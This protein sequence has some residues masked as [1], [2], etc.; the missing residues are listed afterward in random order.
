MRN[1]SNL[2]PPKAP[3]PIILGAEE[4]KAYLGMINLWRCFDQYFE[5]L[6]ET[7]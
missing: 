7:A 6:Q 2:V 3:E 4:R 1:K 5:G